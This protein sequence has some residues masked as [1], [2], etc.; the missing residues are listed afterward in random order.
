MPLRCVRVSDYTDIATPIEDRP[1]PAQH[2][3]NLYFGGL[4]VRVFD[5]DFDAGE[6]RGFGVGV[7]AER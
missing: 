5:C 3:V 2:R 7:D 6:Y 1:V 4:G